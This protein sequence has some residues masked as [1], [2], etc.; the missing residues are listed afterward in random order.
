MSCAGVTV[1]VL[2][3]LD[4][5]A[6]AA[7]LTALVSA[8][9]DEPMRICRFAG[10]AVSAVPPWL[11]NPLPHAALASTSATARQC[12]AA[13][14]ESSCHGCVPPLGGDLWGVKYEGVA[15]SAGIPNDQMRSEQDAPGRGVDPGGRA[16]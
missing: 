16:A 12:Q 11:L 4:A 14:A 7:S 5:H 8:S 3:V 2:P 13:S 15:T 1:T 10:P 6:A 9:P